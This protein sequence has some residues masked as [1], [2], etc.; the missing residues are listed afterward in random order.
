MVQVIKDPIGTKGARLSTQISHRRPHAG[1]PA[2]GLAH[3]HLA[4]H[5][6]RSRARA[7]RARLQQPAA[8]GRKRRLHRAHHGRG[9][10]RRATLARR[11]RLPAQ[12][13]G[14]TSTARAPRRATTLLLPGSEPG[15]ARA[16]RLRA[17]RDGDASRSI[18]AKTTRS[19]GVRRRPTRPA[20][21]PRSQHY[22]GERPLFDLYGVEEEI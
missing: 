4:A 22:T 17:R 5:R 7:L 1:L 2:A 19:C 14:A 18:R 21:C 12:A 10:V 3:R 15:A 13:C 8:G 6:E 20:C 16:A 9:R 11:H